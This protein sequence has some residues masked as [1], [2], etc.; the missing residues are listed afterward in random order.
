M[1]SL[2]NH[3]NASLGT[4][5]AMNSETM[6]QT[7]DG[8]LQGE[9]LRTMSCSDKL[10]RWNVTGIQGA[11]L[12]HFLEPIYLKSIVLGSLY[13]YEHMSRAMYQR[14]GDIE[15]LPP[16]YKQN[17]PLMSGV[18]RPEQ[19]VTSK[20]PVTSINWSEGD[21]GCEVINAMKGTVDGQQHSSRLSKQAFFKRFIPLW[22]KLKPQQAV[23]LSYHIAKQAV[24][25]Y[26]KAKTLVVKGFHSQGLGMWIRKPLEQDM[27]ELPGDTS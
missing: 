12:G 14:L 17:R 24:V 11:L 23:P 22:K 10:C 27:F 15:D 7:W 2:L 8:V 9:R 18:S 5:P 21:E 25:H 1:I 13:H 19:R 26:Q 4:I 20:S 6:V 16:L 3:S